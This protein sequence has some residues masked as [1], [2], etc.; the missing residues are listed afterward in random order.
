MPRRRARPRAAGPGSQK[1]TMPRRA[2]CA[3]AAGAAIGGFA[4]GA[5]WMRLALETLH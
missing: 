2:L 3:A 4:S 1:H 5:R